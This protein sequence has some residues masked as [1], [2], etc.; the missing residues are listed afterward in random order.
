MPIL[1]YEINIFENEWVPSAKKSLDDRWSEDC[2]T[3]QRQS[4]LLW[5]TRHVAL[6]S[7]H[8]AWTKSTSFVVDT[9]PVK[10][11]EDFQF[12]LDIWKRETAHLASLGRMFAH[13]SYLRI[14]ALASRH[15]EVL[16]ALLLELQSDPD[17][18]FSALTAITGED[19]VMPDSNFDESVDKWIEWGKSRQIL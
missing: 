4:L 13:P 8:S 17:H 5:T 2:G 19:P 10:N 15:R 6:S 16:R 9:A 3:E 12:H 14:I 11:I 18:W 7:D 1:E